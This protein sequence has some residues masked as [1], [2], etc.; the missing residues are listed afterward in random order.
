[1]HYLFHKY[2]MKFY[3]MLL[4]DTAF[5]TYKNHEQAPNASK[6]LKL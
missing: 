3:H 5:Q 6:S 2:F 1:M 4:L